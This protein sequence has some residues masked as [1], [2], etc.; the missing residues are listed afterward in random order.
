M[1]CK[2]DPAYFISNY[3][4]VVHPV[5]GRVPF[6]LYKFQQRII[7]EII[8]NRFTLIRKFRQAGVTTI[9]CAY[10]LWYIT[11]NKDKQIMVVSI[12]DRESTS[13]LKRV[14]DM[15][16]NLPPW[17]QAEVVE[18]NAHNLTLKT[19]SRVRSQP[20]GA[21]RSEAVSLLIV[22]E[23]AFIEGMEEFWK[24]IFPTIS[25]GGR[26]ILLST[27]NGTANTYYRLYKEATQRKNQFHIIDIHWKEHPEYNNPQW[28]KV[29]RENLGPRGWRQEVECVTG[30]TEITIKNKETG[31]ILK[32]QIQKVFDLL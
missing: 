6:L 32:I 25:T 11:F 30:D 10:A 26:A 3:V 24:A 23:A 27:V 19:G 5:K 9:M 31:E 4:F 1:K 2:A 21:G 16:S 22:D 15:Y 14:V 17:L 7:K 29:M 20:A 8:S 28:E 12:G 13:F 18:K